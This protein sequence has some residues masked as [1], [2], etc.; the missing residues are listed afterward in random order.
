MAGSLSIPARCGKA[1][2]EKHPKKQKNFQRK[3]IA[4]R[5]RIKQRLYASL[6]H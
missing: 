1:A 6:L 4:A 3:K 5:N 2:E